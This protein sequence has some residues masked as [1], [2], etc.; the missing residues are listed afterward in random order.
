MGTVDQSRIEIRSPAA[1]NS[2]TTIEAS[3]DTVR[4]STEH[5]GNQ[6]SV[7]T[8][9]RST[10][11]RN[12]ELV[13]VR[14]SRDTATARKADEATL[15]QV[16]A[17]GM[18]I[19]DMDIHEICYDYSTPTLDK[20]FSNNFTG[21]FHDDMNDMM[22]MSNQNLVPFLSQ[23]RISTPNTISS[24]F[25]V[26]Q[27]ASSYQI[28]S[29]SPFV[30]FSFRIPPT[31]STGI[32]SCSRPFIQS[33]WDSKG[34]NHPG[35]RCCVA[36]HSQSSSDL[37]YLPRAP[38]HW[39]HSQDKQSPIECECTVRKGRMDFI[40]PSRRESCTT[41]TTACCKRC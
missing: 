23:G 29:L 2:E 26:N 10:P 5:H 22:G 14:V 31:I 33:F 1:Q 35:G 21:N 24:T 3:S 7:G 30:E 37:Q 27:P 11:A 16:S 40:V 4:A 15:P 18:Y 34:I 32:P 17:D 8:G 28:Q 36:F 20:Y 12:A 25:E 9:I 13:A 38:R 39:N 41:R 6:E 19:D